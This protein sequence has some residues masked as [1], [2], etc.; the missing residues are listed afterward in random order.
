LTGQAI[1]EEDAGM[2]TRVT[3][4]PERLVATPWL[5]LLGILALSQTA[6]LFEHVAQ[7]IQ[8]HVLHLSGPAARGVVGQLDIEWVHFIWNGWVL[9]TLLVLLPRFRTNPWLIGVT[10][11]AGWHFVEHC[12]MIATY[13]RTGVT[14]SPGLLSSGGL[15]LGGLPIARPDLHFLYNLVET[16]PLLAGW[17]V[18]LRRET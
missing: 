15:L 17:G 1:V 11:F 14:G 12:V 5:A 9:L 16:I 6:H 4:L 13:I 7:M 3:P 2:A 8:I 18:E 10:L